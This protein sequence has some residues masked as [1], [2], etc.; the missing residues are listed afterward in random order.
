M[1]FNFTI[2]TPG[3]ALAVEFDPGET[4]IFVGAN[5]GGKTRLTVHIENSLGESAHRVSAHRALSM[6]PEVQKISERQALSGLR[7]G[8][9]GDA[10]RNAGLN[11]RNGNRWGNKHATHLLNDFDYLIQALFADQSNTS[12]KA[13]HRHKPGADHS[14]DNFEITKFDKLLEIWNRLLPHRQLH[15]SGD[16]IRVSAGGVGETYPASEMSDGERAIFYMIGQALV[17]AEGTVLIVDE[18]ELHVHRSIMAKLWDEIE[19]TRRDCGFIY[20]THDLDFAAARSAKKYVIRDFSP[21]P[22]WVI[23][24]IPENTGFPEEL[25]TLILGSRR[26]ILFVEGTHDSL[27]YAIYRACYPEWTVVPKSSCSE[28]IHSVVSMRANAS[29]TRVTCSGIV[30]GDDYSDEDV[31]YFEGLGIKIIPVSEIENLIALPV[32]CSAIAGSDGFTG[33]DLQKKLNDV[34][35]GIFGLLDSDEK[36]D[37]VVARHCQ[38]RIDRMLKQIDLSGSTSSEELIR[39]YNTRTAN[40]DIS[41]IV[42]TRTREIKAALEQK[43]LAAL[44]RYYDNKRGIAATLA[45]ALKGTRRENFESWVIRVLA[46]NSSSGIAN[47][48]KSVLPVIEPR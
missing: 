11:H 19:A 33:A 35:N 6:N 34:A 26:P 45:S 14:E 30:D 38:R 9:P 29:L 2:P 28:V 10:S 21:Q 27:D 37:K 23:E 22:H 16:N 46:A 25:V 44:L 18:P 15:I 32:V 12:L 3:E 31:A 47:A 40:L 1:T 7:Y 4:V 17:A 42:E 5:G 13:Y 48:V 41:G 20:I 24:E 36:I 8:Y 43:D 39:D